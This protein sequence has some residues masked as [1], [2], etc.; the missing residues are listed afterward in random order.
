MAFK[1]SATQSVDLRTTG[2]KRN[3]NDIAWEFAIFPDPTNLDKL[4]C[5][6]CGS[7][8]LFCTCMMFD[9]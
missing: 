2:F 4:K 8:Y 1:T 5:T 9:D 3:S 7:V 6:L